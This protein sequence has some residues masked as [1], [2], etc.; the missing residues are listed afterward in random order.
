MTS[1]EPTQRISL[2]EAILHKFFFG[3]IDESSARNELLTLLQ[4]CPD[5]SQTSKHIEK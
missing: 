5:D 2:E 4:K 1:H 3:A